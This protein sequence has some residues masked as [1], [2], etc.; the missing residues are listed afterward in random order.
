MS[1]LAASGNLEWKQSCLF[2]AKIMMVQVLLTLDVV[3]Q[4]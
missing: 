4:F 3:M 1:C 2:P